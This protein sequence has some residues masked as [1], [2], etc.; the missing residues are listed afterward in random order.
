VIWVGFAAQPE[1]KRAATQP[2]TTSIL[3]A[4]S[5]RLYH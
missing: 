3:E 4:W 5:I 2:I 1:I